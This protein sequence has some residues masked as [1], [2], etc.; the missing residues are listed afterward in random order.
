MGFTALVVAN[1]IGRWSRSLL[2]VGGVAVAVGAVV[3]LVGISRGFEDSLRELYNSRGIDL[4]VLQAGKVAQQSSSLPADLAERIGALP[5]VARVSPLIH[6]IVSFQNV[7]G[8]SLQG[9]PIDSFVLSNYDVVMGRRLA[10]EDEGPPANEVAQETPPT[11]EQEGVRGGILVGQRLAETLGKRVGDTLEVLEGAPFRIVGVFHSYNQF[12]NS[13]IIMPLRAMQRLMLREGEATAMFVVGT[14]HDAATLERIKQRI[15]EFNDTLELTSDLDV[16]LA[17]EFAENTPEIKMVRSMA[18]T[19]S[20][21]ALIVGAIGMLNTMLT[22]VF[23][24]T[25]EIAMMRAIGWRRSRVMWLILWESVILSLVGAV[26]G[27]LLAQVLLW[28]LSQLP[29]SG[30][31]V[32]GRL[33]PQVVA[34]G[35]AI[36]LSVGLLGGLGPALRAAR[37]LPVEGLRHD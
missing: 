31:I 1:I 25:R 15:L 33:S 5:E 36:A 22:A 17:R 21:I 16:S 3:A 8:V 9:L 26:A 20:S 13:A 24:R 18:W 7:I 12:E 10:T 30:R 2:T 14:A 34:Q 11:S 29:A 37:M 23:E 19:T 4:I 32:S 6:D 27:V 35:L 28:N